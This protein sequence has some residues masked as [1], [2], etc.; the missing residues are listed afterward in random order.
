M[1]NCRCPALLYTSIAKY[2]VSSHI[3]DMISSMNSIG[4]A[5]DAHIFSNLSYE[6]IQ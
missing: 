1:L 5:G 3:Y 6:F 2:E 4:S